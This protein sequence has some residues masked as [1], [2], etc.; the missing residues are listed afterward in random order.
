MQQTESMKAE[1]AFRRKERTF[2]FFLFSSVASLAIAGY[3]FS[4]YLVLPS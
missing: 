3:I 4:W 1:Q 2:R